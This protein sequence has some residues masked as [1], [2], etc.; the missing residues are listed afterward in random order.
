M[1]R[2]DVTFSLPEGR[3]WGRVVDTQAWFDTPG[4]IDD[5]GGYFDENP[6]LDPYI[7]ANVSIDAPIIL[8]EASYTVTGSSIV[9]LE[10]Q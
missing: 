4:D 8:D 6:T 2:G 7:S 9:I 10:E 1:E 5:E 3:T